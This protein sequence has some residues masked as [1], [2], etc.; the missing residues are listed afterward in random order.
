MLPDMDR[1]RPG[2]F[3]PGRGPPPPDVAMEMGERV[4]MITPPVGPPSLT[5]SDTGRRR[6]DSFGAPPPDLMPNMR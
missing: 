6:V 5:G 1:Q 2:M 4:D 3:E